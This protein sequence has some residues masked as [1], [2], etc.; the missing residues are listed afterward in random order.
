MKTCLSSKIENIFVDPLFAKAKSISMGI[1]QCIVS[2][3]MVAGETWVFN[4]NVFHCFKIQTV[5]P[6]GQSPAM[7]G[8]L[9]SF[10]FLGFVNILLKKTTAIILL[11]NTNNLKCRREEIKG[12]A[13]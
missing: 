8:W 9:F 4:F 7:H 10:I 11:G 1:N 12:G 6:R 5:F 2:H 3:A 13:S